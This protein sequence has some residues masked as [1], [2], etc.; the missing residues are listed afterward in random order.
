MSITHDYDVIAVEVHRKA[1]ANLT[2]EMAITMLRTSGSPVVVEAKDFSCCLLDTKCEHL[3]FAAYVLFHVGSSLIGTQEIIKIVEETGELNP[4]DGWLVNDPHEGGAMHQGDVA[5]IMPM[6][7]DDEHMG[8]AFTNMHVLDVGGVGVSG[9]APGAHDVYQEGMRFPPIQIIRN[10]RI[11]RQ[12]ELYIAANVRTPGPV[13]NDI[14]SMIAA[15]NTGNRKLSEIIDTFGLETFQEYCEINKDLTEQVLRERIAKIPDGVYE[16]ID[17][18]EFDGHDG[19]DQLLEL[20]LTLTFDGSD[21]R[22]AFSGVPQI[23][24]FV[25][26][27]KGPM[28]G[29][30][31]T[32]VLVM[33]A[34]GDLPV[35]GGFVRPFEIDLGEPGSIVN[36]VPPA[37][38]SNAHSEVGM[39]ACKMVKDVL[40]QALAL[41][42]DPVLRGRVAGQTQDGFPGINLFGP[43]QYG[44]PSVIF[45]LD[46]CVGQ[47]GGAQAVQDGQDGYG[48][49]CM[50]GCGMSDAEVHETQD[51]VIFLWR[52]VVKNSGGPGQY[53]G[54]QGL[55]EAL[56]MAYSDGMGGPGFN[57]CAEVP[58][59]GFGGGFPASGG[60][61][62]YVRDSNALELAKDG[63]MPLKDEVT[64]RV[65]QPH[66][67]V[68]HMFAERGDVLVLT[69]GG[70]GG[71]G[72]PLL[73][74]PERVAADLRDG[75]ITEGHAKAAYGVVVG[76]DGAADPEETEATREAI[77]RARLGGTTP[78]QPLRAPASVGVS[79]VRDG[80]G[81]WACGS[82]G[83]ALAS[84]GANW[85]DGAT[86]QTH[87]I[88]ERLAELEM[89]ARPRH[90]DPVVEM[91]EYYCPQCAGALSVD[92]ATAPTETLPAP[93]TA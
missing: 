41:S 90:E 53:R 66:S 55:E 70:G 48:C 28:W 39:R 45:Y 89:Y 82:C 65:E 61:Y 22:F 32:A 80:A 14:R 36:S 21:L 40:S 8:W 87:V 67:K 85:R 15:C 93:R 18:N 69:S 59:S 68:T 6:F 58:P 25:N 49:T 13:L 46:N 54:G 24:G 57:A 37:P 44:A 73:R 26:S 63:T 38:V 29:Q 71:V 27:T 30:I 50:T 12:W 17:W 62:Y 31:A 88:S 19:P 3:G 16:T 4:G 77:R 86:L 56:L 7:H 78:T 81:A 1:L 74:E 75:Y 83:H 84:A 79:V 43:N 52:D 2:D 5:V 33:L 11:D 92:V 42:D 76:A 34:Y 91:R 35:N 23:D 20:R 51:P 10:G 60:N 72:D 64:G 9:Y 47:G